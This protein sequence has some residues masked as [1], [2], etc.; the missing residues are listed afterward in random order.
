MKITAIN[1]HLHSGAFSDLIFVEVKTDHPDLVGWGECT[2]PGKPYSVA[3]AVQDAA[4]LIV[5]RDATNIRSLWE[6]VYRHGYWRGGAIETSALSGI[7]I[8]LWDIAG[9]AAGMPIHQLLGGALRTSLRTYANIGLSTDPHELASRARAAVT[10]GFDVVKFY[11]LP[12]M[13]AQPPTRLIAQVYDCCAAVRDAIGPDR[14][15]AIDLHGRPLPHTVIAIERAVRDLRPLWIEEPVP[16]EDEAAL[17]EVRRKFSTPIALGERLYTRWQFRRVMEA[18]YCDIIQPDVGNAGGI[19][20]LRVL[21]DMAEAHSL[22]FSPH[23]PNAI[24]HTAASLQCA[25]IAKTFGALEYRP[26]PDTWSGIF[27]TPDSL[28][29]GAGAFS[30]PTAPGVGVGVHPEHCRLDPSR[31]PVL[32]EVAPDG[33]PLDW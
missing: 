33:T 15:F 21:A 19:S 18:Q 12:P 17:L 10:S 22:V 27:T 24:L 30:L 5:G 14:D 32:A 9:K 3:G 4:R 7:D 2:L 31:I 11:P 29:G 16:V 8:A 1:C 20:E 6:T 13:V 26:S 28:T 23:S 25:A